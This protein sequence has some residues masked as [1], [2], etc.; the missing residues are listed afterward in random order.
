MG[1]ALEVG[2]EGHNFASPVGPALVALAPSRLRANVHAHG[3]AV[4]HNFAR[5]AGR[6]L[7]R[8]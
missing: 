6:A 4:S 3:A 1:R 5:P 8:S 2:G 7:V